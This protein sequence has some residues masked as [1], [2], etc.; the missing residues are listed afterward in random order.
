MNIVIKGLGERRGKRVGKQI[1]DLVLRRSF[2]WSQRVHV[3]V[4]YSVTTQPSIE[5]KDIEQRDFHKVAKLIERLK[6][7]FRI[8]QV[9][10]SKSSLTCPAIPAKIPHSR[11]KGEFIHRLVEFYEEI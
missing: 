3:S 8:L 4:G 10:D 7:E 9:T 2:R 5:F 6:E 1:K 11:K